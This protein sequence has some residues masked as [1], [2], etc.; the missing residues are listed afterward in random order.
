MENPAIKNIERSVEELKR[1]FY[2]FRDEVKNNSN[3]KTNIETINAN[4]DALKEQN[5][6]QSSQNVID[7]NSVNNNK[8]YEIKTNIMENAKYV[9]MRSIDLLQNEVDKISEK[10][11]NKLAKKTV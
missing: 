1:E 9:G 4:A 5:A 11:N 7:I 6:L 2:E 3:L 8:N 10:F